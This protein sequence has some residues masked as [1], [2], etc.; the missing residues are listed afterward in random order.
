MSAIE[1]MADA[2]SAYEDA[3]MSAQRQF[4]NYQEWGDEQYG[5]I[6]A[7]RGRFYDAYA[8]AKATQAPSVEGDADG[9]R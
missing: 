3:I 9:K 2:F 4:H 6:E 5:P 7:A 1:D 8:L